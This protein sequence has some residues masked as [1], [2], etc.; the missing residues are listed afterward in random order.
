MS[1]FIITVLAVCLV[2]SLGTLVVRENQHSQAAMAA[3]WREQDL[4]MAISYP[5]MDLPVA[6]ECPGHGHYILSKGP[7][8]NK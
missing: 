4:S 8:W 7:W 5:I 2:I 1:K 6:G 3:D